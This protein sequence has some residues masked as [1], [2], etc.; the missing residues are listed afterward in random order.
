MTTRIVVVIVVIL[1]LFFSFGVSAV[2]VICNTPEGV[3]NIIAASQQPVDVLVKV[4][5]NNNCFVS[6]FLPAQPEGAAIINE[7][8]GI[9]EYVT[10]DGVTLYKG[11][12]D[13]QQ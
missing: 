2:G 8:D 4:I 7:T 11:S 6:S 12:S 1:I 10:E 5:E 3:Q 9:T 13:K